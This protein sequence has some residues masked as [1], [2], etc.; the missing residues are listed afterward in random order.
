MSFEY[1]GQQ[2][3]VINSSGGKYY[4]YDKE[5]GDAIYAFKLKKY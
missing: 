4:G 5:F 1:N 3:I 2:Y